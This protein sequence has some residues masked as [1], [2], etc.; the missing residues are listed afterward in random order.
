MAGDALSVSAGRTAA[1]A[2]T[3][4]MVVSGRPALMA[5]ATLQSLPREGVEVWMM[6][7]SQPCACRRHSAIPIACGGQ[8]ISFAPGTKAAGWASHV[9]Y[10]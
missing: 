4:P 7:W 2:P 10:Q 8:S 3:N 6:T 5:S 1:W 9:G